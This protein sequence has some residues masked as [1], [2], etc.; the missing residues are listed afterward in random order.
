M[1]SRNL[2]PR[3]SLCLSVLLFNLSLN[4]LLLPR[5]C[6]SFISRDA[7]PSLAQNSRVFNAPNSKRTPRYVA[8]KGCYAA[9]YPM[10]LDSSLAGSLRRRTSTLLRRTTPQRGVLRR[11]VPKASSLVL[12]FA[13]F[14]FLFASFIDVSYKTI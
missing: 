3:I 14:S 4:P 5:K 8:A 11:C 12:S 10:L 13:L 7:I 9:T 1:I 2:S 6:F